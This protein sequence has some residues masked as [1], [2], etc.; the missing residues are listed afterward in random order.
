MFLGLD[1]SQALVTSMVFKESPTNAL[2]WR[3]HVNNHSLDANPLQMV[4]TVTLEAH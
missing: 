3:D 4:P 1:D 2:M